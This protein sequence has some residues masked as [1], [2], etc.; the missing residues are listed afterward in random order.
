MADVVGIDP[1]TGRRIE[2]VAREATTE[3]VTRSCAAALTGP[4]PILSNE[5]HEDEPVFLRRVVGDG[6][7]P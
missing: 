3:D 5:V 2:V 7:Q 4:L 1:H 6:R